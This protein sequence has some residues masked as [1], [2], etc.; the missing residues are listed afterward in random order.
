M[1]ILL[2]SHLIQE[3]SSFV[4]EFITQDTREIRSLE[5]DHVLKASQTEL[6][7]RYVEKVLIRP[8]ILHTD[9]YCIEKQSGTQIDV[10]HD[11][12]RGG[13]RGQRAIIQGTRLDIAIPYEGDAFLWKIRASTFS[14]SG[15]PEIEVRNNEIMFSVSFPDDSANPAQ[16]KSEIDRQ[17]NS[18]A[19]A[20]NNLHKDVENH[21]K[22]APD[23][24]RSAIQRKRE[25]AES[26]IGTVEKLG[27]P[28][29]GRDT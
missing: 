5:N 13:F 2:V 26:T 14:V 23:L 10:S 29:K 3:W 18:L 21:N 19:D 27:I 17:V 4:N 20:V 8:L 15:Y 7:K 22:S 24:I 1:S 25:L 11:I 9:K 28:I 6:E 16:V 12:R